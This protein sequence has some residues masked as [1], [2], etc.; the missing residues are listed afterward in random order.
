MRKVLRKSLLTAAATTGA[1]AGAAGYAQA[2]AG[3]GG[4]A[5]GSPGVGSGNTIQAP[6]QVPANI[7]GNTVNVVALLNPSFGN[8]CA[9]D[10]S[11]PQHPPHSHT[12]QEE[13]QKPP[14]T[15]DKPSES[16]EHPPGRSPEKP[17]GEKPAEPVADHSEKPAAPRGE[18]HASEEE[19]AVTPAG[20]T[21]P[22]A[23]QTDQ[24]EVVASD[25]LA[26]TGG[27]GAW[28]TAALG[29]GALLGGVVLYRR[30]AQRPS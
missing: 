29:A 13:P 22:K 19:R 11:S 26:Q 5:A 25:A 15:E 27:G 7:C 10:P 18:E 1:L 12:P 21:A 14:R 28:G 24:R 9:N 17:R 20:E 3:A 6:V 16:T 4:G 23:P 30:A 2:D 8:N